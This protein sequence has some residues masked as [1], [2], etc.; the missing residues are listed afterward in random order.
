[1]TDRNIRHSLPTRRRATIERL[2]TRRLCSAYIAAEGDPPVVDVLDRV[3]S[4]GAEQVLFEV[5]VGGGD[6]IVTVDYS[7]VPGTAAPNA[8]YI[9]V[10]GTL[11]F[12]ADPAT[13]TQTV[14][15]PIVDDAFWE[16]TE[17]FYLQLS[18]VTNATL[19]GDAATYRATATVRD[20]DRRP[21][22][23]VA[24]ARVD[25]GDAADAEMAFVVSMS[26]AIDRLVSV[27][28]ATADGTA[29]SPED[30][31][32]A[33]GTLL[34][35]PG[36]VSKTVVVPVHGDTLDESNETFTLNLR[37]A[38][39][40]T[41]FDVQG[42]GTIR[43]D[44]DKPPSADVAN[45]APD[46]RS[47]AVDAVRV[48][49]SEPVTGFDVADLSVTR[50]GSANLMTPEQTLETTDGGV[51]YTVGNL[52]SITRP[53]GRYT[54]TVRAGGAGVIDTG[55]NRL[56]ADASDSWR[57]YS[58]VAGRLVF[59]N[60]SS[61]DGNDPAA[62]EADDA[63]V[64]PDKQGLRPGGSASF[65]NVS[66]Y[67]RGLNGIMI[68]V[69]GLPTGVDPTA[70]DFVM[71]AGNNAD[72]SAWPDAPA[73]GAV[74]VRRGVG[75]DG[76]DRVSITFPDNAIRNTWLRV[77]MVANDRTGLAA[78]D[79]F[80]FGSLVGDAGERLP[81][82]GGVPRIAVDAGDLFAT[83]RAYTGSE[84]AP[85]NDTADYNRDGRVNSLDLA[86]A[87]ANFFRM[88]VLFSPAAPA[89]LRM[90]EQPDL[91]A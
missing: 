3:V 7:T 36:Q 37:S 78:P 15:V 14:F 74:T 34:F 23:R 5:S 57:T 64:A 62:N 51:T 54:L 80:Y 42:V 20:D 12:P 41:I 90:M 60:S 11:T 44:D 69:S 16:E 43:E 66:S 77:V 88:L 85:L 30:Y 46:P 68:D 6:S 83:R 71:K 25:E 63:A 86:L 65:S 55:G 76:A 67:S 50:D 39:V 10:E 73:P 4:E 59:Y 75:P 1:M 2:E 87:R 19:P 84:R 58:V 22:L 33:S 72:T 91:L 53:A 21:S 28:Y 49:F 81:A 52:S 47:E 38:T 17:W 8:D 89:P 31:A 48:V 70:A 29:K 13:R 56:V 61:F 18:N 35:E 27:D 26:D 45:V 9:P 40:A 24:D 32:A 82:N 79:V